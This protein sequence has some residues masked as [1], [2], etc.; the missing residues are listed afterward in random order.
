MDKAITTILL[1]IGGIVCTILVING[2]YPAIN[3]GTAAMVSI[4]DKTNDRLQSNIE[5]IQS[6]TEDTEVYVWVKNVGTSRVM[7]VDQSDIF[8]GK[9]DDFSRIPYGSGAPYWDYTIENDSDW[10]PMSTL[11]ITIHLT[12]PP[13]AGTYYVKIV[14][15]NGIS[16][17]HTFSV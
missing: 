6:A 13:S 16:D 3:R 17:E 14:I 9:P 5:V 2:V 12:T 15:P 8:Y 7:A 1:M 10:V 4:A 11:K